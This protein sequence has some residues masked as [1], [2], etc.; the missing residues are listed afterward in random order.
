MVTSLY[1]TYFP[2]VRGALRTD[3]DPSAAPGMFGVDVAKAKFEAATSY[4]AA[5]SLISSY[6]GSIEQLLFMLP[7]YVFSEGFD[8]PMGTL[9][10]ALPKGVRFLVASHESTEAQA[11]SLFEKAGHAGSIQVVRIKDHVSF[12]DW[13]EDAFV[14]AQNVLDGTTQL[15]EP[16]KFSRRG[17]SLVADLV[18]DETPIKARPTPLIFQGGNC[19]VGDD[20]WLLGEDYFMDT[21]ELLRSEGSPVSMTPGSQASEVDV[22]ALFKVYLDNHRKLIRVGDGAEIVPDS[23]TRYAIREG[24]AF[25]LDFAYRGV[26]YWQPIFHIDMFVTLVGRVSAGA[27]FRVLVGSPKLA[28]EIAQT[29]ECPYSLQSSFD[30]VANQLK[31]RGFDVI[32]NPLAIVSKTD[33]PRTLAEMRDAGEA[34]EFLDQFVALGATDATNVTPRDWYHATHNNCL[35]QVSKTHGNH[36]YLPSF[37]NADHPELASIDAAM[38]ALWKDELKFDVHMLGDFH[39]HARRLGVVHCIKKYLARGT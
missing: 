6:Q 27:P 30:Y 5:P 13:S 39:L 25:F 8:K 33:T 29:P 17:D 19:L 15:L 16:F 37:A 10:S 7:S 2:Q 4:V 22:E 14:G 23:G 11:R 31:S 1:R 35:V 12:T 38:Q 28:S 36:V 26:G 21:L 32:R 3:R 18:E 34:K 24:G 9:L 20:F